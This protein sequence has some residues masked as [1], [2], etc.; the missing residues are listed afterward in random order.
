ML[1][2]AA[3]AITFLYFWMDLMRLIWPAYMQLK[4]D[5]NIPEMLHIGCYTSS[6]HF[7]IYSIG[8]FLCYLVYTSKLTIF[9]RERSKGSPDEQWPWESMPAD[10]WHKLLKRSLCFNLVNTFVTNPMFSLIL[11]AS[12]RDVPYPTEID[13]MPTPVIFA[14]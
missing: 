7:V 12:G 10:E 8:N 9:E 2:A 5:Y 6:Q 14:A 13:K 11:Y 4:T 3:I 1:V